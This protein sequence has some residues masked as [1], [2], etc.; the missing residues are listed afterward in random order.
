[1]RQTHTAMPFLFTLL[2]F[3]LASLFGAAAFAQPACEPAG[4]TDSDGIAADTDIDDDDD[5]LIEICN[6]LGLDSVRNKLDGTAYQGSDPDSIGSM[7]APAETSMGCPDTGCTGYELTEDL[8]FAGSKWGSGGS[9]ATGWPPIG[10]ALSGSGLA[11][12]LEGN[13]YDIRN[14]Y[15]NSV[16]VNQGLFTLINPGAEVR[17]L[18]LLNV[19]VS[20]TSSSSALAGTNQGSVSG[21]H[22]SGLVTTTHVRIGLSGG[23]LGT[24]SGMVTDCH[25]TC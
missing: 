19:N 11:G 8:D 20:G 12:D 5:G 2:A 14:L 24:N 7:T 1:M 13:G 22:S 6:L 23:L 9:V 25:T 21:C 4:F 3:V 15:I 18:G 17:N 16:N 10:G